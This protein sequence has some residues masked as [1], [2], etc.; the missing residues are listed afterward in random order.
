M[1]PPVSE[2][3]SEDPPATKHVH[4]LSQH[5]ADLLEG[6]GYTSNCPSDPI[7]TPGIQAP[8]TFVEEPTRLLEGEGQAE[9]MMWTNSVEELLMAAEM[10]KAEALEPHTLA[11]A[12]CCPDWPLWEKAI[13]EE[14]EKLHQ[15]GTWELTEP[16]ADANIVSSKWVF[17]AKEDAAG[18]VIQ[19][20]ACLVAQGFS[21]VLGIN[22]FDTFMPVAK[23][24]V[25]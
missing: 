16:P 9:W 15:A 6:C 5:I 14:L 25:I 3:A 10:S 4:K 8:T 12:K 22:Y 2:S 13:N 20:K 19:Y 11:K 17:C 18:N 7:V 1:P 24:A 21:Q 23:L